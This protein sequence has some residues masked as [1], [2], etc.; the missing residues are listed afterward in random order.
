MIQRIIYLYFHSSDCPDRFKKL[1]FFALLAVVFSACQSSDSANLNDLSSIPYTP[2]AYDLNPPKFL[3][4][5]NIPKDNPLTEEG[6]ALGRR[7][8]YDPILSADSTMSCATCHIAAANFTDGQA[9]SK[10][11]DGE[12]GKRSAM[13]LLN[14]GFYNTGLF[15][16]GRTSTLESQALIPVEDPIELH[17]SWPN[18]ERKLRAH[19]DYPMYF[20]KAFGIK[21]K[22]ELTKELTVKAIAQFER[23]LISRGDS[24][25][26]QFRKGEIELTED[27]QMGF[28][29]FFDISPEIK[30]AECGNCHN[31]P[32]FTDHK[33]ANNGLDAIKDLTQFKDLGRGA[34]INN[35]YKNGTFRVPTLR[36]IE[37]TAPYMHDGRFQTLE[38]VI[39]HYDSGGQA[40]MNVH[41][42]IRPLNLTDQEKNQLLAFLKTLTDNT[43]VNNPTYQS[44]F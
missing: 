16:D 20:R 26:D 10:G 43:F 7:L 39:E 12:K 30:D 35:K 5:M 27:E 24:R 9:F 18:V 41:A 37:L 44:P 22:Q 8:F 4:S 3:G 28:D 33:Y 6:I 36:N 29:L 21:Q 15:W 32:L 17:E 13:S 2:T 14:V 34:V 42:L 11:I 40:S 19:K 25:F 23:T 38:E 31:E 1:F